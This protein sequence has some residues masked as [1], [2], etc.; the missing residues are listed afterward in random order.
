MTAKADQK[1]WSH[2][3][4]PE[5]EPPELQPFYKEVAQILALA[6]PMFFASLSWVAMK[7][8]DSALLGH[9]GTRYLDAAALSDL[10][11]SSFGV[12]ISGGVLGTF[13]GQALG[14][15]NN[16]LVGVW[17]QISL[18][19][20]GSIAVPVAALWLV[21][22]PVLE[23]FG[24]NKETAGRAWYYAAVL[25]GAFPARV[26]FSQL[27]QFFSAQKIV[28][29]EAY[30]SVGGALLN[31]ALGLVLV[32]GIPIPGWGGIG[33]A[34]CP[35]VTVF[36]EYFQLSVFFFVT[37]IWQKLHL[38]CWP[39]WMWN[40]I[41]WKRIKEYIRQ[42]LPA[43]MSLASDFWR[44]SAIGAVAATMGEKEVGVFNASYRILWMCIIFI[45]SVAGAI[46]ILMAKALGAGSGHLARHSAMTGITMAFGLLAILAFGVYAAIKPLGQI[47]TDDEESLD[48]F[49]KI[50]VPLAG[51]MVVMNMSVLLEKIPMAMKRAKEVL[52]VGVIGSWAAQVPLVLLLVKFWRNDLVALYTGCAL[53]YGIVC[54]ILF[55]IVVRTDWEF[56]GAA[57]KYANAHGIDQVEV[58]RWMV[59]SINSDSK[60]VWE[61]VPQGDEEVKN[62]IS[63]DENA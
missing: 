12:F 7:T 14:A 56:Y 28:G 13:C 48:L 15:G 16:K 41:T 21:T 37:C 33:F 30:C 3:P 63:S 46:S 34:I 52:I 43:A 57:A 45:G 5:V 4:P 61:V 6:F 24:S 31:L 19:I 22:G 10:W 40:E 17:L 59:S 58:E 29:P 20:L 39:G 8:T 26:C 62:S 50:R 54:V 23:G 47:F 38:T 2:G 32:L 60:R 35:I 42:Y 18:V 55:G 49:V 36:V 11:T 44:L 51:M 1:G 25:S 53:G 9:A 27:R